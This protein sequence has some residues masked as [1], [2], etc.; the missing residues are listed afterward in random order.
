MI[1]GD[2]PS[3]A[4]RFAQVTS[5]HVLQETGVLDPI[6]V[7]ELELVAQHGDVFVGG[8]LAE[9][10]HRGIARDQPDHEKNE[11]ADQEEDRNH[12]RQAAQ[13]VAGHWR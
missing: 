9:H 11:Q 5:G 2:G 12:V 7:V 1:C 4:Q 6:R 3:L 13:D 10:D 8:A